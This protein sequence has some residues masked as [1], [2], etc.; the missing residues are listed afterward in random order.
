MG[1]IYFIM[2]VSGA[3]KGTLI[4]NLKKSALDLHI[5]LSYKTRAIRETET[6]WIDAYFITQEEFYRWIEAWEFLEYAI[7][8]ETDHYGTKY[9]DVIDKGIELWKTVLKELDIHGLKRLI[10][11]RPEFDENYSTIFLNI[12]T[13][14]LKS[15]IE[16]RWALMADDELERRINSAI[17]E[18]EKAR[19]LCD[20]MIDATQSEDEVLEEVLSII[21]EDS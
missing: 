2:W 7:V 19:E 21:K 5:P 4:N 18:E 16:K 6:N 15:R 9:E 3:W 11:E 12:P 8:H 20:Y 14:I 13:E 10:K 17:M 1:H